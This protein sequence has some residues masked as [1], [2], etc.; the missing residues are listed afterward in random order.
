MYSL[1]YVIRY[2]L[3]FRYFSKER[4]N[5]FVGTVLRFEIRASLLLSNQS[6]TS[7]T[8]SGPFS[9]SY[10]SHS[11]LLFCLGPALDNDPSSYE[12]CIA[13]MTG[14]TTPSLLVDM[15]SCQNYVFSFLPSLASNL[16]PSNLWLLS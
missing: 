15:G 16:D 13:G 10:F 8:Q 6:N 2:L 4:W 5:F 14:A 3:K 9:F 12:S 1:L 11:I 7:A